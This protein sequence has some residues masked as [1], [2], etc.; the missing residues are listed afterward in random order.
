MNK[1]KFQFEMPEANAERLDEIAREAGV[2]KKDIINNALTILDW[3]IEEVQA[4]RRICSV[5]DSEGRHRE[6]VLPLL[7]TFASHKRSV[8]EQ[9]PRGAEASTK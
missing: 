8:S 3:V 4:G 1:V 6:L 7:R 5:G 2:A 9:A